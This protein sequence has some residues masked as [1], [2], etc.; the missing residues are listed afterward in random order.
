[1]NRIDWLLN[2]EKFENSVQFSQSNALKA[3]VAAY[4][5]AANECEENISQLIQLFDD[6]SE[7]ERKKFQCSEILEKLE[8]NEENEKNEEKNE[9]YEN[10]SGFELDLIEIDRIFVDLE[11][12]K[13]K[14][15]SKYQNFFGADF[16]HFA[17]DLKKFRSKRKK[18][19]AERKLK[20]GLGPRKNLRKKFRR[21]FLPILLPILF[22]LIAFFWFSFGSAAEPFCCNGQNNWRYAFA[23]HL[24][25]VS[26]RPPPF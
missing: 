26:E 9:K 20:L 12:L 13:Q 3:I 4:K 1:M 16:F 11:I 23:V 25:Y 10:E 7:W 19:E 24:D 14:F 15:L 2:G 18:I 21:I 17:A 6:F 5:T 22:I 8:K